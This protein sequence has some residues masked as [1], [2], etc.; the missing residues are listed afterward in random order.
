MV[1]GVTWY[2]YPRADPG[3]GFFRST[4]EPNLA[5]SWNFHGVKLT[6]KV[7]YDLTL[8]GPTGQLQVWQDVKGWTETWG[9]VWEVQ[10]PAWA[11]KAE[12]WA[13]DGKRRDLRVSDGRVVLTGL[14]ADETYMLRI[15]RPAK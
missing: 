10:L 1:P 12:L 4:I 13:W 2:T 11:T 3:N 6:P 14:P 8:E 15:P 7:Y 9:P 5:L